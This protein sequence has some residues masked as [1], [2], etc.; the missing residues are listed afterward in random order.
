MCVGIEKPRKI[1]S[2]TVVTIDE[3]MEGPVRSKIIMSGSVEK[4]DQDT[5][6]ERE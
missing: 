1:L 6:T 3:S 4:T 5:G 2:A